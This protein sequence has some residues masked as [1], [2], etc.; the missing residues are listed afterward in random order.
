MSHYELWFYYRKL[1]TRHLSQCVYSLVLCLL[2]R[3]FKKISEEISQ[4][5]T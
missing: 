4:A 2:S 3:K 1:M 5:L